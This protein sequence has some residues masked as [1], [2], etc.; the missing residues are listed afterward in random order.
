MKDNRKCTAVVLA[1]GSG[2]RMKGQV[3]KQ[4]LECNGKPLIFYALNTMEQSKVI[5]QCILVTQEDKI[6]FVKTEIVDKYHFQKVVKIIAGG[7]E[8]YASVRNAV[9]ELTDQEYIFI[10]DGARP[11]V[12]EAILE[13][14]L[15][16]VREYGACVA[17]VP[18]KDTIK[19]VDDE[20]FAKKTPDRKTMWLVQTP[21]IFKGEIIKEAYAK[22]PEVDSVTDDASVVEKYGKSKIKMFLGDYKNIKVTTPEDLILMK[23]FLC[24]KM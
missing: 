2:S 19:I 20:C 16:T 17:A 8:R 3:A 1:A 24:E 9:K 23:A 14:G 21:Q 5:D 18:A 4:F 10:H 12:D 13:R 7:A 15:E 11:L 6:D 22:M